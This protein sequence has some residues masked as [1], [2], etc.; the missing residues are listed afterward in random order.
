[1]APVKGAR[2][3]FVARCH[4]PPQ[5]VTRRHRGQAKAEL[6]CVSVCIFGIR[7]GAKTVGRLEGWEDLTLHS[8][9]A[10]GGGMKAKLTTSKV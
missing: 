6:F 3:H 4:F 2:W 1:M 7:T 10:A 5:P 8:P 9:P